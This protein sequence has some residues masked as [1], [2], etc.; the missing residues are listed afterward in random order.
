MQAFHLE[1]KNGIG[2]LH[3]HASN[4]NAMNERV[5]AAINA[6]LQEAS[7]ANLSGLI[8][9]GYDR[10]F[11]AGLDL[12]E[13]YEYDRDQMNRF[14]AEVEATMIN[15]FAFPKPVIAA[16][17]GAAAAGG[18]VLALA[19]D[20]RMLAAKNGVIGM[21]GIRL[22]IPLPSAALEIAGFAIPPPHLTYVLYT[23]KLFKSG[24]AVK[25]GLV[26]EVITDT[27]L[28]NATCERLREFTAHVGN[29]AMSLKLGLRQNIIDRIGQNA[30]A[31]RQAFLKTWFDPVVQ[32]EIGKMRN[33]MLEKKGK[34]N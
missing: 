23:G 29:P 26:N 10:F 3:L 15:L 18:C 20:Y 24:A 30:P 4:A 1:Q 17:N 12:I 22:G 6:G 13:V 31:M 14:I 21:N 32:N 11:S 25:L 2:I 5:L 27:E 7:A 9:T 28:L 8:I 33:E 16:I 34:L 19:C